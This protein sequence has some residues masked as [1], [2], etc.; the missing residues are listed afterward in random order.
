MQIRLKCRGASDDVSRLIARRKHLFREIR[1]SSIA[2]K[3]IWSIF[4][5][6]SNYVHFYLQAECN[7]SISLSSRYLNNYLFF[8]CTQKRN[9]PN[10]VI[11]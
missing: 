7:R 8:V 5:R 10:N 1:A 9:T 2:P 3:P 4:E 11:R 6:E